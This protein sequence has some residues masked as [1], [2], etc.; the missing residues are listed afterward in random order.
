M[1]MTVVISA[2]ARTLVERQ[3]G[4]ELEWVAVLHHHCG[5]MR[6]AR[7]SGADSHSHVTAAFRIVAVF[8]GLHSWVLEAERSKVS[9]T[10]LDILALCL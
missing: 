2:R 6:L 8:A 10:V 7:V 9:T 4:A 1:L 5:E 3:F